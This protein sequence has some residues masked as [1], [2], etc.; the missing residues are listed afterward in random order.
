M[1]PKLR[2]PPIRGPAVGFVANRCVRPRQT[3]L[4]HRVDTAACDERSPPVIDDA[5]EV[6]DCRDRLS[7]SKMCQ[8]TQIGRK[9]N[10]VVWSRISQ[11]CQRSRQWQ[12]AT[13]AK[14]SRRYRNKTIYAV[15]N[16]P[17]EIAGKRSLSLF[18]GE[19][20]RAR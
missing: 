14:L 7:G 12:M 5:L 2:E 11:R 1:L 20:W 4:C 17:A 19:L 10:L 8:S 13:M 16:F 18:T 15:R 6:C 9:R 3:N